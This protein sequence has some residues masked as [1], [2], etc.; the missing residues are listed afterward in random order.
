MSF[1]GEEVKILDILNENG[2]KSLWHF[3]DI[4]NLP[5]I[6][7]LDGLRSKEYLEKN[8]YWKKNVI[9]SGGD[10]ISHDLDRRL[11]NWDK[12]SLN[13]KSQTPIAYIRKRERY[14]I[15]IEIKPEIAAYKDVY[16]TDC[17]AARTRNSQKRGKGLKG[18]NYV[19]F[20]MISHPSEPWNQ[21]WQKYVQAEVLVPHNIPLS[22][23]KAIHFI[24]NA[25]MEYGELL[26]RGRCDLFCVNSE[27]FYDIYSGERGKIQFPYI[28]EVL[29]STRKVS[30]E[31]IHAIKSSDSYLLEGEPF[32]V[33]VYLYAVTGTGISISISDI[34]KR[35]IKRAHDVVKREFDG[36]F[37]HQF[38]APRDQRGL[39]VKVY[40]DKILWVHR[41][42]RC[43]EM[44]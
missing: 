39:E 2:I 30:K 17:N 27:T 40:I 23:F 10:D 18:L 28:K 36:I 12:I 33:I 35:N 31:K 42:I 41:R 25:S 16:F 20:S 29:I 22:M 11:G 38:V 14:L 43:M 32:W 7:K 8:D 24:S 4:K 19:N 1:S 44:R 15:F 37:C 5:Y 3:T 6:R 34:R 13:F 21:D 9:F 26:W